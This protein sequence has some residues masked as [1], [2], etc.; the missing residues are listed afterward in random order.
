ME[1]ALLAGEPSGDVLG[2]GLIDALRERFPAARFVGIGGPR[3]QAAGLVSLVSQH[4]L[5]VMGLIEVLH[6]LPELL[7]IRRRLYQ[8]W[9]DQPPALF[10]GIDS[11]D[12]NLGLERR[13]RATGIPT[14]HYVSP[15]VWAWR[16]SR[17]RTVAA[18]VDLML[19]LLPFEA[20]FYREHG[21]PVCYVGHP[22]ADSIPMV[23]GAGAQTAARR[24]LGLAPGERWVALLPGSRLGEVERLAALFL[25]TA[26]WLQAQQPGL[27]FVL[28]AA[29]EPVGERLREL[30]TDYPGLPVTLV[31]GQAQTV[32]TAADAALVASGTATLETLLVGRPMVV[33]YRL[34]PATAWLAR[35]LVR[36]PYFA[37]PNLLAERPLVPEFFQQAAIPETLGPALLAALG[38]AGQQQVV[39][40]AAIHQRLRCDANHTAASAIAELLTTRGRL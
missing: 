29:T 33:A 31:A 16:R 19:T 1:I 14:V 8:R 36:V 15:S 20:R 10:V 22:L 9:R 28:P 18:S 17:L 39:A 26:R 30:L 25:S 7:A 5:A 38:P 2:A 40:F 13:L 27:R 24:T 11:P 4:Q 35:R 21:V 12:F 3:M 34:A 23:A 6:H 32:L 37:L